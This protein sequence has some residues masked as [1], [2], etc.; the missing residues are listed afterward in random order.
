[1]VG[2]GTITAV[3]EVGAAR[4]KS[5]SC[6]KQNRSAD[7]QETSLP[8]I[9]KMSY[10]PLFDKIVDSSLWLEEDFVVKVFLTM[11]AKQDA[12]HV[13][14]A[15]AFMIG[16]W[17]KKGEAEALRAL[18]ILE[19]PD[20]KR[21]VPQ[22]YE[23][24]RVQRVEG[25]WLLLNGAHYQELMQQ[26]N[27]RAYKRKKE[28]EYRAAKKG[29]GKKPATPEYEPGGT[30][31]PEPPTDTDSFGEAQ[32]KHPAFQEPPVPPEPPDDAPR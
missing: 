9:K 32:V 20:T 17:S 5:R 21:I 23:G 6:L 4:P 8:T 29:K 10:S 16:Q 2:S 12:D 3:W 25:G 7:G 22:P 24:R 1:M 14:R 26:A 13:V 18:A 15:D 31:I 11:I 28:A 19:A 30:W 27:R